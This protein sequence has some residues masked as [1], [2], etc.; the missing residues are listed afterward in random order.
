[1]DRAD[2]TFRHEEAT[3]FLANLNVEIERCSKAGIPFNPRQYTDIS[4]RERKFEYQYELYLK[5]KRKSL[6]MTR[7]ARNTTAILRDIIRTG[8]C[9]STIMM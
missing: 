5:E 6:T 9:S 3:L 7:S 4:I 1:M 2:K 8:L